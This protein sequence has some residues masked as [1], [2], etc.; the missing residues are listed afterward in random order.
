MQSS[1]STTSAKKSNF[2]AFYLESDK[3]RAKIG[4]LLLIF[5]IVIFAINDFLFFGLGSQ[6]FYGLAVLRVGLLIFTIVLLIYM[7]RITSYSKYVSLMASWTIAAAI[8]VVAINLTRPPIFIPFQIVNAILFLL[9]A[10]AVIPNRLRYQITSAAIIS[11]GEIGILL[12]YSTLITRNALTTGLG[13]IILALIIGITSSW[14]LEV[15]R[16]NNFEA[17]EQLRQSRDQSQEKYEQLVEKLPEMVFEINEKGEVTFANQR[18]R[19]LTGYTKEE[20]EGNFDA[21]RLVAPEDIERSRANMKLMFTGGMRQS[22]EYNWIRKDGTRFPVLLTSSAVVEKGKVLGARGIIADLTERK[23]LEKQVQDNE[24]L[25]AIGQTAGMVGHDIRNPLQAIVSDIYL[26][27][28]SVSSVTD[29]AARKEGEESLDSIRKNVDYINKIVQDLQDYAKSIVPVP[30]EINLEDTCNHTLNEVGIPEN[31]AAY[32]KVDDA[33][34]VIVSDPDLIKR[35]LTNLVSN[36]IH[37][38]PK[39]GKLQVAAYKEGTDTIIAVEDTGVGISEENKAKL[40]TPLFTTRSK[41][42]GFGL[43]VIKRM[44]E[45]LGGTVTFESEVGK[46]AKFIVRLPPPP[47][48][49][50]K[51]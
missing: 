12:F 25:A 45:A 46:G 1:Q 33:V 26:L 17:H 22:N 4:L 42:Q 19:E 10:F 11:F 6:T 21:N 9:I 15:Y 49:K 18:A 30:K 39:G 32:C 43:P 14:Q 36:A 51:R 37:A 47:K 13:S 34:K 27:N 3:K 48:K 5:P 29:N 50:D 8:I 31:I 41:G 24:R 2:D 40:F 38:M 16:K 23:R 7:N 35:I 20:L 44:T 28:S